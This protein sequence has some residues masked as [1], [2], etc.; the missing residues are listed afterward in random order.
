MLKILRAN[1]PEWREIAALATVDDV[2]NYIFTP[3]SG[4]GILNWM[5]GCGKN[6][7]PA[8]PAS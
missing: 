4:K 3:E 8:T 7:V 6:L 2:A 1:V 5:S